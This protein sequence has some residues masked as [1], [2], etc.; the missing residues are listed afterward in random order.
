MAD[1]FTVI[2]HEKLEQFAKQLLEGVGVAPNR[3]ALV[4][5]NLIFGN[6]RGVDSHGMQLLP[7]YLDQLKS[8][9]I[10]GAEDGHALSESGGT[11]LYN[12]NNGLGAVTSSICCDHAI[13][14]AKQNGI[15]FVVARDANHFGAA[16]YWGLSL[17][18]I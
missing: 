18:H 6:L 8:G 15:A 1:Q 9:L 2:N 7:Y 17:I 3:A 16:A 11:M 13:R 10:N 12:A 14:L 5:S 4:A